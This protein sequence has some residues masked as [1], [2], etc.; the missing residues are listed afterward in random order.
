MQCINVW[1]GQ[2]GRGLADL[3]CDVLRELAFWGV[4]AALAGVGLWL[5]PQVGPRRVVEAVACQLEVGVRFAPV[6]PA[7]RAPGSGMRGVRGCGGA[8]VSHGDGARATKGDKP[9]QGNSAAPPPTLLGASIVEQIS[10]KFVKLNSTTPPPA[11]GVGRFG[12]LRNAHFAIF[13]PFSTV[14][15]QTPL[16][17]CTRN[18]A[19]SQEK[20]FPVLL[21]QDHKCWSPTEG[22]VRQGEGTPGQQKLTINGGIWLFRL[23]FTLFG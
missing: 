17:I 9:R 8:P 5:G 15:W 22:G 16:K 18:S 21:V 14:T 4:G 7:E 2:D 1:G 6:L 19:N 12:R 11:P 13:L 20:V 23:F 3:C 10:G